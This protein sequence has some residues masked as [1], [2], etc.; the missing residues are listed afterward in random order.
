MAVI[1]FALPKGRILS[2]A[3]PL[4]A[5]AGIVPD[6]DFFNEESRALLFATHDPGLQLIRVRAFDVATYVAAGAAQIGIVGSD[7]LA[8]FNYPSLYSPVDLKIGYC[9]LSLAGRPRD[10]NWRQGQGRMRIATKYPGLAQRFAAQQGLQAEVVKLSGALE[11]APQLGMAPY[12]VDLVSSGQ[13]LKANGLV[14]LAEIMPVSSRL[15]VNAHAQK[16]DPALAEL[17]VRF[18]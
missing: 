10:M 14:E 2:E 9:R 18:N 12:I 16:C 15:I 11:L 7:V 8:E 4:L 13:T 3:A 1:T 6:S 17:I 5:H